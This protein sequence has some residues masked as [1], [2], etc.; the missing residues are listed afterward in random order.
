MEVLSRIKS[1]AEEAR[2]RRQAQNSL[3]A[4]ITNSN[5]RNTM[6]TANAKDGCPINYQVEGPADAPVLMLCNSLGTNLH[7]WDDQAAA[8]SKQFRLV[9]YDRRGHGKSG[10]P[11]GPYTMDMLGRDAL[12]VADAAGAKKFNWCG[13][14][15][16]GMVGQWMGAN[17]RDRVEKLVLSNTHYY[18]ADKQPWHDRIKFARDNGLDKLSGPQ[19]ERWFTKGFRDSSPGPVGKVVEMFTADQARRL[20]RLL[21]GGARH[22]LPRLDADHHRAGHGHRRHQGPGDVAG[23]RPGD[24]QDDQGLQDRLA[25]GRASVQHRAAQGLHRR[26]A[27]FPHALKERDR[28]DDAERLKRGEAA[29]RRVLGDEWVDRSAKNR[30][31]FNAEWLD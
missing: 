12:A 14:S 26:G 10:A 27:E 8:W 15:M 25:R 28:M 5:T 24:Q 22:G 21:R 1:E 2:R 23:V 20:H 16:G 17:A 13:L 19:M 31:A 4:L 3:I 29:R 11:K 30:N 9:R 6:P 7:M 18:Y